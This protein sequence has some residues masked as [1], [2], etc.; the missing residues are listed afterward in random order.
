[1]AEAN[2]E[3]CLCVKYDVHVENATVELSFNTRARD[4]WPGADAKI[5]CS[6]C[7]R[8]LP[9]N[10]MSTEEA[11]YRAMMQGADG[12]MAVSDGS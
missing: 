12:I 4:D 3:Q 1:M 10:T 5:I 11:F 7:G 2:E 6:G 9:W 8:E